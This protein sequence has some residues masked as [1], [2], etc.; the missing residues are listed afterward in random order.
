MLAD[1]GVAASTTL[2]LC[3]GDR[4]RA[5]E[6]PDCVI[7]A[8]GWLGSML[9]GTGVPVEPA[10]LGGGGLSD[11]EVAFLRWLDAD[12][13]VPLSSHGQLFGL[14]SL[15]TG[16]RGGF[17]ALRSGEVLALALLGDHLA[18]RLAAENPVAHDAPPLPEPVVLCPVG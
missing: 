8:D 10:E 14:L 2:C 17:R 13:L 15:R 12:I 1:A 6:R 3:D 11:E 9:A 7:A 18:S 5:V 4:L 16:R